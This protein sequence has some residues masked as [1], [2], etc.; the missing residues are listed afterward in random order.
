MV[1][2]FGCNEMF[3]AVVP[4]NIQK[5]CNRISIYIV[6]AGESRY[7][8]QCMHDETF[9]LQSCL[10]EV[11]LGDQAACRRL[12]EQLYPLVAKIVA[13][14]ARRQVDRDDWQQEIFVR[15]FMRRAAA[16]K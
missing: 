11:R 15:M 14:S 13:G 10:S 12:V 5:T 2:Y 16:G 3:V 9:D 1:R 6:T 7:N 4:T 8:E